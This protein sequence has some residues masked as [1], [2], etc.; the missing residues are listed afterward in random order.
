MEVQ[1]TQENGVQGLTYEDSVFGPEHASVKVHSISPG[2][3][4]AAIETW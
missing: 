1:D 4:D 3:M 2:R